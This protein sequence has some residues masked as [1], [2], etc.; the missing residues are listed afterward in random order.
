[1][2]TEEGHVP[3]PLW[4]DL[5]LGMIMCG[6]LGPPW[7]PERVSQRPCSPE[8][9]SPGRGDESKPQGGVPGVGR[10]ETER[11]RGKAA[12]QDNPSI[13]LVGRGQQQVP[14]G[15]PGYILVTSSKDTQAG[16]WPGPQIL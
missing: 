5:L 8:P 15:N 4:S 14:Q 12:G 1:M 6:C 3:S 11:P 9:G 2:Q 10:Q 13:H 16:M 7:S